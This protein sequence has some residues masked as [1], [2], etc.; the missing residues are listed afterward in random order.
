MVSTSRCKAASRGRDAAGPGAWE[1]GSREKVVSRVV[2]VG[3]GQHDTPRHAQPP[4]QVPL[5]ER[6]GEDAQVHRRAA[7]E[8]DARN[9]PQG[10]VGAAEARARPERPRRQR[11]GQATVVDNFVDKHLRLCK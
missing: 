11:A 8:P 5:L 6:V 9:L 1:P 10:P 2:A 7:V 3:E 4:V